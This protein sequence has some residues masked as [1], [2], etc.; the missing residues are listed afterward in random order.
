MP[1]MLVERLEERARL[2][3][4]LARWEEMRDYLSLVGTKEIKI[5]KEKH[6][7]YRI[8]LDIGEVSVTDFYIDKKSYLLLRE[9]EKTSVNG[10][11]ITRKVEYRDYR[12]VQGV[13]V[14]FLRKSSLEGGTPQAAGGS[15]RGSGG[16]GG[17]GKGMGGGKGHGAGMGG[18]AQGGPPAG[19][20]GGKIVMQLDK[21]EFNVPVDDHLFTRESLR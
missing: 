3:G 10:R 8:R 12:K 15:G 18:G 9:T 2:G 16:G 14:A 19:Q 13:M 20:S 11:Q 21:V 6:S 7:V 1:Q 4:Y 5:N 17:R